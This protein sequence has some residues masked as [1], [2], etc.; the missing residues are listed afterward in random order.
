MT[1]SDAAAISEKYKTLEPLLDERARRLR[2]ATETR[3]IGWGGV[4]RL[5]ETTGMSCVTVKAGP[6]EIHSDPD[7]RDGRLRRAGGGRKPPSEHEPGLLDALE[8]LVDPDH[9]RGSDV[10]PAVDRQEPGR[11][12]SEL[13]ASRHDVSERTV[14]LLHS[15]GRSLQSNPKTLEGT[16][17]PDRDARRVAGAKR[18]QRACPGIAQ[19]DGW[20]T[21]RRAPMRSISRSPTP[22]GSDQE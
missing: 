5:S 16:D 21:A 19:A 2:A 13:A 3:A 11:L 22:E 18:A 10:A 9:A 17:H 15:P 20:G 6:D 14:S 4:S 1:P 7:T 8:A 12:A